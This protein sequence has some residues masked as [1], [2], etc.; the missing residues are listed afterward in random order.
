[1]RISKRIL[2]KLAV[3]ALAVAGFTVG[4]WAQPTLNASDAAQ[5][6]MGVTFTVNNIAELSVDAKSPTENEMK[7]AVATVGVSNFGNLGTVRVKTNATA[8]DVLMTTDNGGRL[9][10]A[11]SGRKDSA[12]NTNI[13]GDT[14]GWTYSYVNARALT[15]SDDGTTNAN[16]ILEGLAGDNDTVLLRVALGVAKTGTALGAGGGNATKLFPMSNVT[17]SAVTPVPPVEIGY[18]KILKSKSLAD[19]AYTTAYGNLAPI[20][21]ALE[22]SGGYG[23][24]G[25][26]PTGSF[27]SGI[28]AYDPGTG[29]FTAAS[30]DWDEIATDGFPKPAGN[31]DPQEEYF[32]I[33]VQVDESLGHG[34]GN[35]KSGNYA[36]TFYFDLAV[37]F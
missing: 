21:F 34:L 17:S 24:T 32:Y 33:N 4:A 30:R 25:T 19:A 31:A 12:A 37:N 27:N 16:G 20:S 22:L 18:A 6:S 28:N 10:D 2:S 5:Q 29:V 1:M 36:E 7:T 23:T 11:A 14:T 26:A 13:W 8:W 3:A 15:Y 35:N 9:L